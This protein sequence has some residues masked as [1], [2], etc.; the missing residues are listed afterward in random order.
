MCVCVCVCVYLCIFVF[1]HVCV[2]GSV[3]VHAQ[4]GVFRAERSHLQP[5]SKTTEPGWNIQLVLLV[6]LRVLDSY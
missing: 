3:G 5:G 2:C 1:M 6:R 4:A